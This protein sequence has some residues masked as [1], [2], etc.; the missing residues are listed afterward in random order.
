VSD[1]LPVPKS[2]GTWLIITG[3]L[4]LIIGVLANSGL[5][6][7]FGRLPGDIRIERDNVRFYFPIVTMIVISIVLSLIFYFIGKFWK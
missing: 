7:W 1:L 3:I 4:L 5:L 2:F 6:S